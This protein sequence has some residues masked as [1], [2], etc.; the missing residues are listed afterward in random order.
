MIQRTLK[1]SKLE[2]D[3]EGKPKI[4][5]KQLKKTAVNTPTQEECTTLMQVYECGEWKWADG[6][7]PTQG[8]QRIN[9]GKKTCIGVE[10]RFGYS[11]EGFYRE[12]MRYK[13]ISTKKFYKIQ[14]ITSENIDEINKWFEKHS[15]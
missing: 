3:L 11:R 5:L 12:T 4:T 6:K 9:Y 14:N 8:N 10:S 15:K 7:L 1:K 2:K 13:V